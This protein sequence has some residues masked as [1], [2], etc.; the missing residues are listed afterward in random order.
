[1]LNSHFIVYYN[2]N[3]NYLLKGLGGG[4]A[5]VEVEKV[6]LRQGDWK[7]LVAGGLGDQLASFDEVQCELGKQEGALCQSGKVLTEPEL[8]GAARHH[9]T[10]DA[11]A[12]AHTE[13]DVIQ[14][15]LL[16]ILRAA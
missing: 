8:T 12:V 9:I 7:H 6:Y 4:K 10:L 13:V 5:E 11:G 16:H 15:V 2:N 3:D 14:E 1:M